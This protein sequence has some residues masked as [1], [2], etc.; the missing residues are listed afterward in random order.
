[1]FN[2]IK[3]R[4]VSHSIIHDEPGIKY[5]VQKLDNGSMSFCYC[6]NPGCYP[7][8]QVIFLFSISG[9]LLRQCYGR[10]A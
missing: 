1:M 10:I 6:K 7:E 5:S 2:L 9:C 3:H 8:L 4:I